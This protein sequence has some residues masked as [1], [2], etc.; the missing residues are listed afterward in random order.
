MKTV[1]SVYRALQLSSYG[2]KSAFSPA[3]PAV[4]GMD[5][6]GT[7]VA[8]D[9]NVATRCLGAPHFSAQTESPAKKL[10]ED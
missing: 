4:L 5:F 9:D 8:V 7:V 2:P 6:A 3:L 1:P 10:F